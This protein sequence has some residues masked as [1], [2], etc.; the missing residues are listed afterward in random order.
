MVLA[1]AEVALFS[2]EQERVEV[3]FD[4]LWPLVQ[5]DSWL[6]VQ[7]EQLGILWS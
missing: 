6:A 5:H 4:A 7:Q 3:Q 1:L 2:V